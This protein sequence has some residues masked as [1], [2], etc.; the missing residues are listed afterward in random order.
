MKAVISED[1]MRFWL[2]RFRKLDPQKTEHRKILIDTFVNAI[3]LYDDK[4][5][6]TFNFK[7][8]EKTITFDELNKQTKT[9]KT[10]SDMESPGER[11]KP[12]RFKTP[13]FFCT[14]MTIQGL[15]PVT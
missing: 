2:E 8:G 6:L 14:I 1:F 12:R 4:M 10:G 3:F 15:L 13:G 7:E 5:V 9:E 11:G